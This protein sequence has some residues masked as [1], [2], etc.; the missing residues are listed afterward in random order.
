MHKF[1]ST[2]F[3][4]HSPVNFH[5]SSFKHNRED[6]WHFCIFCTS[7]NYGNCTKSEYWI[8]ESKIIFAKSINRSPFPWYCLLSVLFK[9]VGEV[10]SFIFKIFGGSV[11][12]WWLFITGY[13]GTLGEI[14]T[15]LNVRNYFDWL[16]FNANQPLILN[17]FQ[18][19][20]C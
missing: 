3:E 13:C 10:L 19:T 15:V 17:T 11:L 20:Q 2:K 5:Y 14:C 4:I 8:K 7:Q 18:N 9:V 16:S 1:N 12:R 6:K